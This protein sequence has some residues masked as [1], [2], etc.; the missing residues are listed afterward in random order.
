MKK[1]TRRRPGRLSVEQVT[2]EARRALV[3]AR[4]YFDLAEHLD[5]YL[6]SCGSPS[7]KILIDGD[8]VVVDH[9]VV[10]DLT[11]ELIVAA[12]LE[13]QRRKRLL[14]ARVVDVDLDGPPTPQLGPGEK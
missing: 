11:G 2:Q 10:A 12:S 3:R 5:D 7:R 1:R 13:T 8:W 6:P 14:A 9:D 4:F